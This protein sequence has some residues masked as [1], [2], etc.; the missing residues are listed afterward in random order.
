[1]NHFIEHRAR[2]NI[3]IDPQLLGTLQ[4]EATDAK[5]TV[6]DVIEGRIRASYVAESGAESRIWEAL[7]QLQRDMDVVMTTILPLARWLESMGVMGQMETAASVEEAETSTPVGE[8]VTPSTREDD[9]YGA[10][11]KAMV[12]R[13]AEADQVAHVAPKRRWF[14]GQR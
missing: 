8:P 3:T 10:Q 6:S 4:Q 7:H 9:Y 1:M 5:Q 11:L 2:K 13:K 14:G 12:E